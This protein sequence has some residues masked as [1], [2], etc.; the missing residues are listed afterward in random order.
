MNVKVLKIRVAEPYINSDQQ[1]LDRFLQ[2]HNVIK[3]ESAFVQDEE[4]YCMGIKI[5][6][7]KKGEKIAGMPT[8]RAISIKRNF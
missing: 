1:A 8:G 7:Q 2:Q 5:K 4:N 6:C 3:F